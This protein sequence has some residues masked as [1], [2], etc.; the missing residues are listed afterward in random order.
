MAPGQTQPTIQ[1]GCS[2]ALGLKETTTADNHAEEEEGVEEPSGDV[3]EA[4]ANAETMV[5]SDIS[6]TVEDDDDDHVAL[7]VLHADWRKMLLPGR[8]GLDEETYSRIVTT[9][10][11]S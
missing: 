2:V 9:H 7:D 11:G 10:R 3:Q 5:Q 1:C 4:E 8:R 6:Y